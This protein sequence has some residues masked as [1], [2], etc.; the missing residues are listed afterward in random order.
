VKR[1]LAVPPAELFHPSW[2]DEKGPR[3][4]SELHSAHPEKSHRKMKARSYPAQG[5]LDLQ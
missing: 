2:Y 1:C 5:P 4:V 3:R